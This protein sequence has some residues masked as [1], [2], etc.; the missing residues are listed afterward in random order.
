MS[1]NISCT[2]LAKLAGQKLFYN[3]EFFKNIPFNIV[4]GDGRDF[5]VETWESRDSQT[6][7]LCGKIQQSYTSDS[8]AWILPRLS[9]TKK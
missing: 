6:G 9:K 1:N 8:I 7:R 5:L 2:S 4:C 3:S